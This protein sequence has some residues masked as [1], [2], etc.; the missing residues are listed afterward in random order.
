MS[1]LVVTVLPGR[2]LRLVQRFSAE[3]MFVILL[4]SFLRCSWWIACCFLMNGVC[5]AFRR[6]F[7]MCVF[8]LRSVSMVLSR[9]VCVRARTCFFRWWNAC[10]FL[11]I[12]RSAVMLARVRM[13]VSQG[14][15]VLCSGIVVVAAPVIA[16][17][18]VFGGSG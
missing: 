9:L 11:V 13:L 1:G 2:M 14:K 7:W 18:V 5:C 17:G 12:R 15:V 6:S 16:G 10:V 3:F 8:S 4:L